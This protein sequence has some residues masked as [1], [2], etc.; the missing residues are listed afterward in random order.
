MLHL[1]FSNRIERLADALAKELAEPPAGGALAPE[2]VV[3]GHAG[4]D[5]WL[6]RALAARR[7][8]AANLDFQ[9]PGSFVWRLLRARDPKL[10]HD[11]PLG[12][13]PLVWRLYAAL[14]EPDGPKAPEVERYL[15]G[16]DE[17][18][19][20]ELAEALSTVFEQYQIYRPEWIRDWEAG[21]VPD[22]AAW[23]A[24]LWRR[25][26]AGATPNPA[27]LYE[28]FARHVNDLAPGNDLPPRV[29]V[30][31]ISALAPAYLHLLAA[32]AQTREVFLFVPNPSQAYWG[33]VEPEAKLARW[34]L[35]R[36]ERAEYATTG[37][38]L[39]SALGMQTRD[40]I[41]LL[42][43]LPG[44]SE[45]R[46]HYERPPGD[47]LLARL[48]GDILDLVEVPAKKAVAEGDESVQV[49]VCHSR[50]R[51]VE[52][53]H[54]S[55]LARF[56]ADPQLGPEDI[57]VMAPNIDDYADHIS[58]VFGAAP[59]E[60]HIPWSL[61]DRSVREEHPIPEAILALLD[62]PE[63]RL[64]VSEVIGL[65]E[66]PSV[67][68]GRGLDAQSLGDLRRWVE[69]AGVR[70]G[71][72]GPHREALGLPGEDGYT[73]RFGL[74]RLLA[75]YALAPGEEETWAGIAPW[76][77]FEGQA[78]RPLGALCAFVE[79]LAG[80]RESLAADRPLAEWAAA[81]QDLLNLFEPETADELAAVGIVR[82]AVADLA[83]QAGSAGFAGVV[84]RTVARAALAARLAVPR[85]PRPF[86]SG[87]VTFCALAPM[88]SI[89]AKVVWLLGMSE[90]DFPRRGRPPGFD[91]IAA[92][93][94]RGDRARR[95][96]DRA[97]FLEALGAARES[98]QVSYVGRSE[99]DDTE[100]PPS[101]VVSELLDVLK[102][103]GAEQEAV[104][105]QHP[106]Q[107]FSA[108]YT[109]KQKR[110]ASYAAEWLGA[111]G[112]DVRLEAFAP[113]RP[114][115][116]EVERI[117]TLDELARAF[118]NPARAFQLALGIATRRDETR[119]DDDEPFAL[120]GLG[121]WQVRDALLAR[122]LAEGGG[123]D[124]RA[125]RAEFQA[126]GLLPLGEAGRIAYEAVAAETAGL[127]EAVQGLV[128]G[129]APETW[130]VEL[131][132]GGWQVRGCIPEIYPNVGMVR[133]RAGKVRA[134]DRL[135]IWINHLA[136]LALLR[137]RPIPMHDT[138]DGP[139]PRRHRIPPIPPASH[140][141]GVDKGV[142]QHVEWGAVDDPVAELAKLCEL[143]ERMQREA[144]PLLPELSYAF[145]KAAE[146]GGTEAAF[147]AVAKTWHNPYASVDGR[148]DLKTVFRDGELE[149]L[150]TAFGELAHAVFDPLRAV[151][152][153][154]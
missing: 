128:G 25:V 35:L 100:L 121:R 119:L 112:K 75:G 113:E 37:H 42:H 154:A 91:L 151:E 99:R 63:S 58:A 109:A 143:Y 110:G 52:V 130:E 107:P 116:R 94:R 61:A 55:L 68:R 102:R 106:L 129:N 122:W 19:P 147:A 139:P 40:F 6:K 101:V 45:S 5:E 17:L 24:G 10:P 2:T 26:A 114:L 62:L 49:H 31:G 105:Q 23:Q 88:R 67:A 8:I 142:A 47:S 115:A 16:G 12:R 127:V 145:S 98:F 148:D 51:E 77:E 64:R 74:D 78:A 7:G 33:D 146:K 93:P 117:V 13:G 79:C 103:M 153:G 111:P 71:L 80:W 27:Q 36:P 149:W 34:Q 96:E 57:L 69:A 118:A 150:D 18:T 89:P 90:A 65:L 70:W 72:D 38:P 41:E 44:D 144:L 43:D 53:L 29:S 73:W 136:F 81:M 123:F 20:F 124:P 86:L 39:L 76:G 85:H 56:E 108:R 59:S 140:F 21:T 133:A 4:M 54:D 28:D 87:R 11:S 97:L 135:E 126:R 120:D 32:L 15:A 46:E 48:Q 9:Q 84:P 137:T 92:N 14:A 134:R 95:A 82:Q 22:D 66:L 60:R 131:A 1:N 132:A 30:F 141:L 138:H 125:C 104:V 152:T 83:E 50:Q 3:V